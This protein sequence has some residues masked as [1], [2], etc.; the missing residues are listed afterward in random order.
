MR[1]K[2][3]EKGYR[4]N[5]DSILL[6]DFVSL[7]RGTELLD[8]G[9]GCGVIGLLLA[10]DFGLGLTGVDIQGDMI[11]F[12]RENAEL[13]GIKARFFTADFRSFTTLVSENRAKKYDAI[14]CNPPFY[15]AATT[16]SG[17]RSLN[18]ARYA[19]ALPIDDF[20]RRAGALL[21]G[22]GD[23]FFCYDAGETYKLL[24]LLK[25]LK[26]NVRKVQF[27]HKDRETS[28]RL[29]FIN[30]RKS[31]LKNSEVLPPI[32]MRENGEISAAAKAIS[33]RAET[34]CWN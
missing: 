11:K 22:N 23:L 7:K 10:R 25:V 21:C 6:Y 2:Q 1:L 5:T 13:N 3:P 14:V 32:F 28:A 24:N 33:E 15:K 34:I 8:V 9:C 27:A 31:P 29:I 12:A 18:A 17:D 4:Y 16:K 26:W 30:A 20:L 19:N